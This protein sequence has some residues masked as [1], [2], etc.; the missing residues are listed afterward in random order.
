MLLIFKPFS[1]IAAAIDVGVDALSVRL[2]VL[3]LALVDVSVSVN[4]SAESVSLVVL[5][6]ALVPGAVEP[7]LNAPAVADVAVGNPV[8]DILDIIRPLTIRPHTW[9]RFQEAGWVS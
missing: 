1:F 3:P 4:Q 2:V 9:L 7:Y 5:P 8:M 6:V